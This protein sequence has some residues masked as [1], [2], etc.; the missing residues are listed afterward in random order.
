MKKQL[1][2]TTADGTNVDLYTLTNSRGME[3]GVMTYG[4]IVTSLRVPDADGKIDDVVLGFDT[5]D[6]HLGITH[7]LAQLWGGMQ[8]GLPMGVL[9]SVA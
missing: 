7:I 8:T 3:V 4:A 6:G 9:P 1:F 2:G 5:L